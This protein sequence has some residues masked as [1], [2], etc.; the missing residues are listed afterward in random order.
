MGVTVM[1]LDD[2]NK[3]KQELKDDL[4]HAVLQALE[5]R[6]LT[7]SRKWL[8]SHEVMRMLT[9]SPNTLQAMRVNG[10]LPFTKIGGVIFY[11]YEDI[12]KMLKANK[13]NN[14]NG[15]G[16]SVVKSYP[17]E[18]ISNSIFDKVKKKSTKSS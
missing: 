12:D 8:K 15:T 1:T 9:V 18:K 3:F 6:N 16:Q 2:F 4:V 10:S 14:Q 5:G 13:S 7:P 17:M 11:D